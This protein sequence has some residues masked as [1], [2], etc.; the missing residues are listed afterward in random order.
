[1]ILASSYL[2]AMML[3][4]S[5]VALIRLSPVNPA[6]ALGMQ[7][8]YSIGEGASWGAIPIFLAGGFGGSLLA[9][10]FF[11]FIYKTTA[12][13]IKEIENEEAEADELAAQEA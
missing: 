1:M 11:R 9:F 10:L 3:A 12:E 2:A 13:A 8:S 4:G 7:L 6:T 5:N